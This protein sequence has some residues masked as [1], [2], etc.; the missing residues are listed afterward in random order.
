MTIFAIS[1]FHRIFLLFEKKQLFEKKNPD[2]L[3]I[4]RTIAYLCPNMNN[5]DVV[6][7]IERCSEEVISFF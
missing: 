3:H 7:F 5:F 4:R 6:G 2:V 1:F